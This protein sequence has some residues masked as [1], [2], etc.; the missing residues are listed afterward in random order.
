[1]MHQLP[2]LNLLERFALRILTRSRRTG[3]VVVKPYGYPCLYVASD[4]TD[5]V[6]AYVTNGPE[7]PAS[8]LL[9]R[10]YHQPAAGELE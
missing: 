10:I 2:G 5:P 9:E 4:G 3:L 8:M 6:A 1:M 7:E